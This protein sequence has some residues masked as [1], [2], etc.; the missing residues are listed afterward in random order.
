MKNGRQTFDSIN[1]IGEERKVRKSVSSKTPISRQSMEEDREFVSVT[2]RW[3]STVLSPLDFR[4][5][6]SNSLDIFS[7]IP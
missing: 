7:L 4:V 5:P 2:R 6:G 3:Q 1:F